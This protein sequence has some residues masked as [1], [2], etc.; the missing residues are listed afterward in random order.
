MGPWGNLLPRAFSLAPKG[1][2]YL[3]EGKR[4]VFRRRGPAH[5]RIPDKVSGSGSLENPT[6]G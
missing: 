1:L 2:A 6:E 5:E 3:G 4:A